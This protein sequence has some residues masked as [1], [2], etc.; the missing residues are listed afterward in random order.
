MCFIYNSNIKIYIYYCQYALEE[1]EERY[2]QCNK[3]VMA[4]SNSENM[5]LSD[6]NISR[7]FPCAYYVC[8]YLYIYTIFI[9]NK[10]SLHDFCKHADQ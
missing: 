7:I 9:Q 6:D 8:I 1:L 2:A 10:W 4:F 5:F 3:K